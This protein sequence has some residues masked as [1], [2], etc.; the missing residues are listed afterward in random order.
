MTPLLQVKNLSVE[1]RNAEGKSQKVVD[2]VS[3][4]LQKGEI[5]GIVGES[6]SGK[7]LT[8]LSVLGLLPYPQARHGADASIRFNGQELINLPER[9]F[10]KIRGNQIGFIFQEPMSSLNPL[11][12][13][14][15]QIAES[16][17]LHQNMTESAI[18]KEVLHLL[19]LTGIQNAKKR[20]KA[21]P[22]ELSGGQRQRVMI[23]MAIANR[24][25]LL[26]ADE[27]T[28]ALDAT[29]QEQ[30]IDLLQDLQQQ[31]GMAV[32][33]ISH[34][35]K[36]VQKI[37]NRVLV[38]K[39]GQIVEQGTPESIFLHPQQSYTKELVGAHN[40][41]KNNNIVSKDIL[42]RVKNLQVTFPLKKNWWG[43]VTESVAA[44]N[45]VSFGLNCH[46][47]L[48]IIGESGSG[49]TTLGLAIVGLNK[50]SGTIC[51]NGTNLQTLSKKSRRDL[52]RE[53][54]IVF[55][56]PYNSLN[57]R[58]TVE[59][60]VSEGLLAH[61]PK[62]SKKE[63]QNKVLSVINEV[64]LQAADMAKYPFEFSGGQ[65][66]RI[67]IARAL[68]LEPKL[69]ILDEPTSAL[70]VTIQAQI[71][72]LLQKIQ[73]ERQISYIFIS[74]DM[75]AVR[76]MSDI[77]AVMK[78]GQMIELASAEKIFH[79]PQKNYTKQLIAAAL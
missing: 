53:I 39:N 65:R 72:K 69:L 46:Q 74:H 14:E 61:Y 17:R 2:G 5:L 59:E 3:F 16:L 63:R 50:F 32:I 55:Q 64:G 25:Q 37:A 8:A 42:L 49:K 62:Q 44:V 4:S 27:P 18:K 23:A 13:V 12:T 52:C 79:R 76:A 78:N 48:G 7:S 66:Q 43:R 31:L 6:G 28:T 77:I 21:Y 56:D 71:I 45:N 1:F 34:D 54:Q 60:I 58:M 40:L 68:V 35:L 11:H 36:V 10:T 57:P 20:M 51:Y 73:A 24:P 33:F 67:A 15:K 41:L 30:I 9:D 29:V 38:M 26:I 70:D 19:Q 75:N 22:F 47:T